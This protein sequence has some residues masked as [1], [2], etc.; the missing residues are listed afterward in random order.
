MKKEQMPSDGF[1]A[2]YNDLD[3]P[4]ETRIVEGVVNNIV[5]KNEESGYHVLELMTE[6]DIITVVGEIPAVFEGEELKVWGKY[7]VHQRFGSQFSAEKVERRLPD[8]EERIIQYLSS[9]SVKGIGPVMAERIVRYF[10]SKTLSILE[11]DPML[12]SEVRGISYGKAVAMAE[13]LTHLFD[14]RRMLIFLNEYGLHP[15]EALMVWRAL[16]ERTINM[17]E[18]NPYILCSP[19]IDLDFVRVDI[20]AREL[21][22]GEES[23]ERID[24]GLL[25]VLRY[26]LR[27]GHTC[28]PRHKTIQTAA[29]LLS[30]EPEPVEEQL[31]K[32][33]SDGLLLEIPFGERL[34]LYL[35]EVWAAEFYCSE[36]I[37]QL[38]ATEP[39]KLVLSDRELETLEEQA[40]IS[41][42]T[43]QQNAIRAAMGNGLTVIT[44]GPGTGKTTVMSAVIR[45]LENR[46]LEAV[47][48]APTGRAAKRLSELTNRNAKTIHRLLECSYGENGQMRF[49][50]NEEDPL[51][52]DVVI[53]DEGSMVDIFLMEALLRAMPDDARLIF[54]GDADQLPSVGAGNLMRDLVESGEVCTIRLTRI[55]RQAA[56]SL[57]VVNA[58]RVNAGE[59]IEYKKRDSDFFF[60]PCQSAEETAKTVLDLCSKRLPETYQYSPYT[61]IQVLAPGRK[62]KLGTFELN[63]LLQ[64]TLNPSK[65]GHEVNFNGFTYR[66]GDK[67]MQV[68]N[69]Y[70]IIWE[71][72]GEQGAGLYNGD[73]GV[74]IEIQRG[75]GLI[76]ASFEDRITQFAV[77]E[78][79]DV[80]LAYAVTV[81]KS[82]GS[83]FPAVIIPLYRGTAPQLLYRNLLYTAIT[84]AR[85]LLILVGSIE[86]V[87]QMLQND[88]KT[89]RYTGLKQFLRNPS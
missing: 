78:L 69:N 70:D 66:V 11:N 88:K 76:T 1:D 45:A 87:E 51:R 64:Q 83:E 72:D 58:H 5:Y 65:G 16:G 43:E 46:G 21:G 52:A 24:S 8:D 44:G 77:E 80:E 22:V 13:G 17:V 29:K 9:G 32:L 37:K 84:R 57:I 89:L 61:D 41:Y 40:G 74:I 86:V 50:K 35:P 25:Y 42:E 54:V 62:G 73:M 56:Q 28:L 63:R 39:D 2:S 81:H 20:I 38:S 59:Q 15:S 67:I 82:Q 18:E 48:A 30:A 31:N 34:F 26:N 19:G 4:I 10:G 79:A 71:R 33:I 6:K 7:V 47:L 75:A 49:A 60:L 23:S 68:R 36:R 3:S 55:F 27:N 85:N 12:L 53:V 14:M